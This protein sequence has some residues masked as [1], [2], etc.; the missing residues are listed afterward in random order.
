ME[1]SALL[2]E[3][4]CLSCLTAFRIRNLSPTLVIPISFRVAWS[5]S[6]RTSPRMS[7]A[8]NV[9]DWCPHLMSESHSAMCASV[10]DRRKSG[11]D[12][13]GG[14]SRAWF[15]W[16]LVGVFVREPFR[17]IERGTDGVWKC[18]EVGE[19]GEEAREVGWDAS[20]SACSV[21]ELATA[22]DIYGDLRALACV[23]GRYGERAGKRV[24]TDARV[25]QA[26]RPAP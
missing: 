20:S 16:E 18:T 17:L 8:L 9:P 2:E 24:G 15:G 22:T 12:M 5:S 26:R 23:D 7:F 11:Y 6:R 21:L 1:E 19:V 13:P 14:G 3:H 4:F 10:Q 25:V